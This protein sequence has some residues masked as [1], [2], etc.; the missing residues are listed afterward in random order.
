MSSRSA[1]L[2]ARAAMFRLEAL[3]PR[4]FLSV[5]DSI[6]EAIPL[7]AEAGTRVSGV[8]TSETMLFT[9]E[10]Q[11]GEQYVFNARDYPT[12]IKVL[13]EDGQTVLLDAK[14]EHNIQW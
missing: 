14:W 13:A 1:A 7:D 5:G 2:L 4:R 9:F 12:E 10:A 8:Y 6:T 3:E 11:A